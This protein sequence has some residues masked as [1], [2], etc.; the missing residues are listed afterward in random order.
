MN[1]EKIYTATVDGE[2]FNEKK[3]PAYDGESC[4]GECLFLKKLGKHSYTKDVM[5]ADFT[6]SELEEINNE[7][8]CLYAKALEESK[9]DSGS[10]IRGI[11]DYK[12]IDNVKACEAL[13]AGLERKP[14][15]LGSCPNCYETDYEETAKTVTDEDGN[16]RVILYRIKRYTCKAHAVTSAEA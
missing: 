8:I 7:Y 3:C 10:R 15:A 5:D 12:L 1:D 6:V 11:V 14:C 9:K 13:C 16:R 4:S 2:S